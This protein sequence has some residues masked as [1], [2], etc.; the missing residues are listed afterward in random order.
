MRRRRDGGV[1]GA[2]P[3]DEDGHL[4]QP[5]A[6]PRQELLHSKLVNMSTRWK[7]MDGESG[8]TCLTT[9]RPISAARAA[10]SARSRSSS[11]EEKTYCC[12]LQDGSE[13]V[14]GPRASTSFA[15]ESWERTREPAVDDVPAWQ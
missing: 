5:L 9:S 12:S 4:G 2:E 8:R 6:G 1:V 11:S 15:G 14:S 3:D 10:G 7:G 13:S